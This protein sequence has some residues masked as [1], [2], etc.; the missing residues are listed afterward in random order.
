MV[1]IRPSF[2]YPIQSA[3]SIRVTGLKTEYFSNPV[4]ID[5]PDPRF[6][7]VIE[8]DLRD[9]RQAAWQIQAATSRERLETGNLF[10]DSGKVP[11]GRSIHNHLQGEPL[12]SGQRYYWRVRV[13]DNKGNISPW[14][15][16]AFWEMGLPGDLD[17]VA[18]WIEPDLDEDFSDSQ[19]APM[20]RSEFDAPARV[21]SARA[22]VTAHGL[23]EMHINGRRVGQD[24]FTPGWTSY[25][26]RLQYQTYDITG[27]LQQGR[28]A[29]GV[30]MGDGWFRGYIGGRDWQRNYYGEVLALLAQVVIIYEDGSRQIF[31][32]GE[33]WKSTTGPILRSDIYNGEYY[34][35]RLEMEKWTMPGY[36]DSDWQGVR[37]ADHGTEK[38]IAQQAP[39]VRMIQELKPVDIFTTP[40]GETVVD[41]G[42]NMVGWIRLKVNGEAGTIV[43]LR[44]A[45]VLDKDGNF[46]TDNLR[47]ARQENTYVLKGGGL[48]VWEPRFT[49]QGFRYVAV[50]G[51]P[52]DLSTDDLT[53]VVIHSAMEPSGHFQSSH[54]LVNH[55]QHNIVWGQKGNFLDVPTDCPQRDERM[56]WTGDVQ[57]FASTANINMNTAGF[58]TKWLGDL[59]A[60]QDGEGSVPAVV[61][62]V[63][64]ERGFGGAGWADAATIVPWSLYQ[65]FGDTLILA[66]QYESMKAWVEYM[67]R[68]AATSENI[69]L[70][71]VDFT[72]GDWL[73]FSTSSNAHYPGAYTDYH[74]IATMYFAR[75]TYLL[76]KTAEVLGM[77]SDAEEYGALFQMIKKAFI[78]EYVTPGGRVMSD[79]QTAYLL[80]LAFN[81]L[82]EDKIPVAVNRLVTDVQTRGHLTTGFLGTPLLNPILSQYGHSKTAYELLLR[83]SYPSWLYPVTMGATTIW[84]RWDGIKPDGTFQDA[85]M[86]SF[87]HFA[88]GAIGEWL[89]ETVAGI[90]PRPGS[91][92]RSFIIRPLPGGGMDHAKAII[93]SIYGRIESSW[94]FEGTRFII[95]VEI[96]ANTSASLYLP[97]AGLDN[98]MESGSDPLAKPG[99]HNISQQNEDVLVQLGSG[100]YTFSYESATLAS[101]AGIEEQKTSLNLSLENTIGELLAVK[102]SRQI[103]Y[104]H[105]PVLTSSPWLSQVMGFT[106]DQA[107]FALP[108]ELRVTEQVLDMIKKDLNLYKYVEGQEIITDEVSGRIILQDVEHTVVFKKE[109]MFTYG[110]TLAID[111]VTGFIYTSF[112][113]R[114]RHT[115]YPTGEDRRIHM[116]SRDGGLTWE[117]I[118]EK[119]SN[120]RDHRPG[121]TDEW[122]DGNVSSGSAFET[123]DGALVRIGRCLRSWM[124]IDSLSRYENRY[125]ITRGSERQRPGPEYEGEPSEWFI[126]SSGGYLERSEDGGNTWIRT[127]VP[128]LDTYWTSAT[129]WAHTQL[130]DGTVLRAFTISSGGE[131][132]EP[133]YETTSVLAV[134]TKDGLS[135]ETYHVM[136]PD[137]DGH[138]H[139]TE[140]TQVHATSEGVVWMLTR[141]HDKG[142][143]WTEKG[144]NYLWQAVS[145]DGGRTWTAGPTSINIGQSPASGLVQLDDGRLLMVVGYRRPP[146]GIHLYFSDDEGLT[147]GDNVILRNDGGGGDIGYPRAMQLK[148]GTVIAIYYYHTKDD[149]ID[150]KTNN[151]HIISTR[152]R[153]PESVD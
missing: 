99:V 67:R 15:E 122:W 146:Q 138:L 31:S 69:Y 6:S 140:E 24:L 115:H 128:E 109:G 148:D 37:I 4:G 103:L 110:P 3:S 120:V 5:Q 46:Y 127:T 64:R 72:W 71:D 73:S 116:E 47:S 94:E 56:G 7:W 12:Q 16:V 68:R 125:W 13:W 123:D 21:V 91:G 95:D 142:A 45:E 145:V 100:R 53:G 90:K 87:N 117:E 151:T 27:Y 88:Y 62:N 66:R 2:L 41:M 44:H 133:P 139:F 14:S 129:R 135:Y 8:S 43:T 48:E 57:V 19:P 114:G 107:M 18:T 65:Y 78:H 28:N 85:G 58:F 54:P 23:Y 10:W 30:Y 83:E 119:P 9:I 149:L 143:L 147:W 34:D 40:E 126:F 82:P 33:N 98:V 112:N 124:H 152:F 55:L 113:L 136:G 51:Y 42:Q 132:N 141:V 144:D 26:N 89:F 76:H 111:T 59:A 106:I 25:N 70:W 29:I 1:M 93:N 75:S 61:P 130:P 108:V 77:E 81:L 96:P 22:Y 36:D 49:F 105:L 50:E 17:W 79:T 153:V 39:P 121:L 97:H 32:T 60:D 134:L 35:A 20:L 104:K 74:M 38:L 63:R 11:S 80:A 52:G 150:G 131:D 137:P 92:Y 84:E 102:H 101:K 86:N 118:T